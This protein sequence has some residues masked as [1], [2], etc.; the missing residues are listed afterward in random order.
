MMVILS[1]PGSQSVVRGKKWPHYN[2]PVKKLVGRESKSEE[3]WCRH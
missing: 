1:T 2:L 3:G